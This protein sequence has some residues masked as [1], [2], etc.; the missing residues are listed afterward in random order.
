MDDLQNLHNLFSNVGDLNELVKYVENSTIYTI[1]GIERKETIH[2][3]M[4]AWLLNPEPYLDHGLEHYFLKFLIEY[5]TGKDDVIDLLSSN[6]VVETEYTLKQ[7]N[8]ICGRL[9]LIIKI[10][11]KTKELII[12]IENKI[13][14]SEFD[15][16]LDSYRVFLDKRYSKK[17][18][19]E[20]YYLYLTPSGI[21]P[22]KA[23]WT[24]IS[25]KV[26]C[27]LLK[28]AIKKGVK[29]AVVEQYIQ[30]LSN[31][32]IWNPK[33][34]KIWLDYF[35]KKEVNR[36]KINKMNLTKREMKIVKFL[37]SYDSYIYTD[38]KENISS[39]LSNIKYKDYNFRI[40]RKS[41]KVIEF[42]SSK[43]DNL[44]SLFSEIDSK[45][46]Y[47]EAHGK[48]FFEVWFN[49]IGESENRHL[50]NIKLFLSLGPLLNEGI[51]IKLKENLKKIK[52]FNAL[53]LQS[54]EDENI[55]LILNKTELFN[56]KNFISTTDLL[57]KIKLAIESYIKNELS[58]IINSLSDF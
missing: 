33:I 15:N 42:T 51:K 2:S 49:L 58:I 4:L 45:N 27:D 23:K 57:E 43:I 35:L 11:D 18:N 34:D 50:K 24:A 9:D 52:L 20:I 55:W 8:E 31:Y 25:Y 47:F 26:I 46:P 7:K 10:E 40:F 5:I 32:I 30:L 56:F 37:E 14:A 22:N 17:S 48:L 54:E 41:N 3:K 38:L 29:K 1:L 13:S 21:E 19:S 28:R 6:I 44:T 12:V 53:D 16:Q 39:I 36:T